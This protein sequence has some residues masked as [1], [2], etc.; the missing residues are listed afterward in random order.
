MTDAPNSPPGVLRKT[1]DRIIVFIFINIR[2]AEWGFGV[3]IPAQQAEILIENVNSAEECTNPNFTAG[4]FKK[5]NTLVHGN[6]LTLSVQKA[7]AISNLLPVGIKN[8]HTLVGQQP[9]ISFPIFNNIRDTFG[10][11]ARYIPLAG[12]HLEQPFS[13]SFHIKIPKLGNIAGKK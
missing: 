10:S 7:A 2:R 13:A 8:I 1:P 6:H 11:I 4:R 3:D 5:T 9:K 12:N